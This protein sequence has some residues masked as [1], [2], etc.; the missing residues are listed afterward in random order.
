VNVKFKIKEPWISNRKHIEPD[1]LITLVE[2]LERRVG[3]MAARRSCVSRLGT[4]DAFLEFTFT[5]SI[6]PNDEPS[7][8]LW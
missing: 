1:G 2:E 3:A 8:K 6:Q 4:N 7:N 5:G